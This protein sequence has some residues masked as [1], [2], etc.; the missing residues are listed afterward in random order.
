MSFRELVRAAAIL[1]GE[2]AGRRLEKIVQ[3]EPDEVVLRLSPAEARGSKRHLL[4]SCRPGLARVAE[5]DAAPAAPETPPAFVSFLRARLGRA[6]FAGARILGGDRQLALRFEAREGLFDLVL[7]IL[8]RRSNLY[9]LDGEG[10]LAR[11]LRPLE[12]TRPEFVLGEPWRDPTTPL[13]EEGEDRWAAVA[14]GAF[15]AA[16]A[17][18]YAD[19]ESARRADDL[20]RRLG[21]ALRKERKGADRRAA[22]VEAELAEAD[23]ATELQRQGELLK[24]VL[25][26]VRP[27]DREVRARDYETGE[28]VTIPLD[29]KLS[30]RQNLDATFKRYQKLLRRLTKAGGQVDQARSRCRELEALGTELSSLDPVDL[31]AFAERPAVAALLEKHAPAARRSPSPKA[32]DKLRI[33]RFKD[34]PRRLHPR[35]Y[36]SAD[37]L[38]IWVGRNDDGNDFLSTRLARGNDL[39]FHLDGAPGSHVVLR[40]EGRTDP[41]QES[42]LDACELAVHFSKAKKAT[43]AEVHVVPIKQVKKPKGAKAGLV[44]VTGGRSVH[45]RREEKRLARVLRSRMDD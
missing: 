13:R 8:G 20:A 1:D 19:L 35:R 25:A 37:G 42:L 38:E 7:S 36:R 21:V 4:L 39:F 33:G 18:T 43:R 29:P 11:A 41:P 32:T 44:W 27:G 22:K 14:D 2:L 28:E 31:A 17:E 16:V 26:D 5:I 10:R 12:V 15:L 3:C 9:V 40:T 24:S 6:R 23:R 34:V 45:L 30:A